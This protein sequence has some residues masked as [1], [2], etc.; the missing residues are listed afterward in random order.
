M[1]RRPTLDFLKTESGAGV[2]LAFAALV[3][4]VVANSRWAPDYFALVNAPVP[5]RLGSFAE[6]RTVAAWVKDGLMAI[7]FLVVGMEIKFEVLRGELSSPR[8]LALPLIAALGGMAVPAALYLWVNAGPGGA[9]GGWPIATPTDIAF[10]L[11]GLAIFAP[12]L[13]PPLRVFLLTLAIADDLG[14]VALIAVLFAGKIHPAALMGAGAA[15]AALVLVSRWRRAPYL[16]YAVGFALVWAFTLKSGVNT[17]LAGI[18]CALTVPV[19]TRRADRDSP[20]KDF[21]DA[22]HPYVAYAILPLFAFACAGFSARGMTMAQ[23]TS[24]MPLGIMVGLMIGKPLG[25]F[26][27]AFLAA[28]TRV[29]RRPTGVQWSE[30]LGA[31]MLCGAGFTMSLFMGALAFGAD[32][33]AAQSNVR[34]AVLAASVL[35]IVAGGAVLAW[36]QSRR[37]QRGEGG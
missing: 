15:L 3:A 17:S 20:L 23:V 6:V 14:A 13:P 19:T 29:G 18:A 22:L 33:S 24:P 26:G 30:L 35:S 28:A 10:A 8:R 31:S 1:A 16:F 5:I 21:M 2:I 37:S 34:V 27:F 11:S 9:P 4:V 7:F 36:A 25:V 32:D 12:K